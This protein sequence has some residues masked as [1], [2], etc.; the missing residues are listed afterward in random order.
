MKNHITWLV[1][2]LA[3][4]SI[5]S[6]DDILECIVNVNPEINETS[7]EPGRINEPYYDR[8]TAEINNEV[9]DDF[10]EYFFEVVGDLPTGI[11]IEYRFREIRFYGIPEE[12]GDFRLLVT[13]TIG[14]YDDG[15]EF[16]PNPTCD[17]Q[18]EQV[19]W[20]RIRE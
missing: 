2:F 4:F 5:L 10:Y 1:G 8:I 7:L 18:V 12:T 3:F 16:D 19:F 6:C 13:L 20:L 17:A 14:A 11:E 9:A 15:D